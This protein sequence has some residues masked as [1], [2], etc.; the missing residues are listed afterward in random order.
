MMRLYVGSQLNVVWGR[1]HI[2]ATWLTTVL[3]VSK[4]FSAVNIYN[5]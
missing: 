2:V 1:R 3:I 5:V 4:K